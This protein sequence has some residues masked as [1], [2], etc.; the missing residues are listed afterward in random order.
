MSTAL[1]QKFAPGT[2]FIHRLLVGFDVTDE[3]F[4]IAIARPGYLD[5]YYFYGAMLVAMNA[6]YQ[7][8]VN[9][10]PSPKK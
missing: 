10:A 9:A 8:F 2:P 7:M 4:G 6:A 3:L 1:S 5:P